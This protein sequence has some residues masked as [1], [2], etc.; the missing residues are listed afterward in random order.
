MIICYTHN[1][2]PSSIEERLHPG[3][4]GNRC[5]DPQSNISQNLGSHAEKGRKNCKSQR[6][7]E[8]YKRTHRIN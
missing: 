6:S 2:M 5:R 7:Q 4:E 8:L 1:L 3:T